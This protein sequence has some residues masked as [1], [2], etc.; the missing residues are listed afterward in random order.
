VRGKGWGLIILAHLQAREDQGSV[1]D[2]VEGWMARFRLRHWRFVPSNRLRPLHPG[3]PD[4]SRPVGGRLHRFLQ[5]RQAHLQATV[6]T[7]G[8]GLPMSG[9]YSL[10]P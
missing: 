7:F 10:R 4:G 9:L 3:H 1:E 5:D 6:K 8:S 2:D